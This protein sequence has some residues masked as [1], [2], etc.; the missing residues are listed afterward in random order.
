MREY[1]KDHQSHNFFMNQ[2]ILCLEK[3]FTVIHVLPALFKVNRLNVR[4]GLYFK[5]GM[6]VKKE[7]H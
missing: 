7:L 2:S 4:G 3:C 6:S 1:F 5:G